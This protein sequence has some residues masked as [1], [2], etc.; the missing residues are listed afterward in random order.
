MEKYRVVLEVLC[1]SRTH[2]YL[3]VS[4]CL[5]VC[6]FVASISLSRS[7]GLKRS[8]AH[9]KAC[10]LYLLLA[11][12]GLDPISSSITVIDNLILSCR[13]I[14]NYKTDE[15]DIWVDGK[16]SL[17]YPKYQGWSSSINSWS[18]IIDFRDTSNFYH[19]GYPRSLLTERNG[20]CSAHRAATELQF[21]LF[22]FP[23]VWR[24]VE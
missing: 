23:V 7:N 4:V 22:H 17:I 9:S 3:C 12:D 24:N 8:M 10:R 20:Y 18:E 2:T 6:L 1:T 21:I 5:S 13:Y 16:P 11:E 15:N 19:T 14:S